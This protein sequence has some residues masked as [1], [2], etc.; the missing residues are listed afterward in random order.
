[1]PAREIQETIE[2]TL[3]T[4]PEHCARRSAK[5]EVTASGPNRLVS[6]S[7]RRLEVSGSRTEPTRAMPALFTTTLTSCAIS[8]AVHGVGVR[9]I[10]PERDQAGIDDGDRAGS[11]AA[12]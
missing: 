8:A 3:I 9:D 10:E 2:A 11:R 1:V 7:R 6:N 12:A 5:A 4:T